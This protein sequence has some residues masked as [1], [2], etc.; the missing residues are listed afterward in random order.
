MEVQF[1]RDLVGW[2]RADSG[3]MRRLNAINEESPLEAHPPTA[4]IAASASADWSCKTHSGR[5][6]RV[7]LE[8]LERDEDSLRLK[9]TMEAIERRIAA[10]PLAQGAYRIVTIQFL[11]SRVERRR[12]GVRAA[13]IE[14][15]FRLLE[16]PLPETPR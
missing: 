4:A 7:A 10:L 6:V 12:R 8:V 14:Y 15:R 2:L 9:D 5:E 11:R 3:L 13:L 1:R 16:T